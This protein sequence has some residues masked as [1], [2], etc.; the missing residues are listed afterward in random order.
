MKPICP[1]TETRKQA[2]EKGIAMLK[3]LLKGIEFECL[4]GSLEIEISDLIYDTRKTDG[5]Q[6]Y[7]FVCLKGVSFDGHDFIADVVKKGASAIIVQNE[8]AAYPDVTVIRVKDTRKA[9]ALL[10]A[11]FFDYP[12]EKL[13]LTAI[14]GTKGKTTTAYMLKGLLSGAGRRTGIIGTIGAFYEEEQEHAV[15]TVR[16]ETKNTTPESYEIH[17]ILNQM[18]KAGVTHVVMEVSSQAYLTHRVAG[19]E[20]D[21]GIFTNISPDHI[22]EGEHKD[23]EDYL[24][25]KSMLF[26]HC[27][28]GIFNQD[29]EKWR[30]V[31]KG[32]KGSLVTFGMTEGADLHGYDVRILKEPGFLGIGFWVEGSYQMEVKVGCL[33]RF[34]ACNAMAAMAAAQLM[35]VSEDVVKKVMYIIAVRGRVE[36]VWVSDK[37]HLLIDYAHNAVSAQSLLTTILEYKPKRLI[38]V[39]GAGGNRSRLRRYDMGEIAG[40]YADLSI[41]TADNPRY[42]EVEDII[43]D[44]KT[45]MERTNGNYIEIPDRKQAIKYSIA[46]A[47]EGDIIALFGKGHEEYQEIKGVRYPFDE[48]KIIADVLKELEAEG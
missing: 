3:D 35:G 40:T 16:I 45:G 19:M 32:N 48:R 43:K 47:E 27:K 10:S 26:E 12:A 30:E 17:S 4:N 14:T 1:I 21:Y 23:F 44:I 20:F 13:T 7:A 15:K 39:F 31:S 46:H 25:C 28:T 24:R 9:L 2:A 36:P 42:E 37:F 33:G 29:D 38:C 6:G 5:K 34:N 11:A 8:T 41:L 22:G 18:V